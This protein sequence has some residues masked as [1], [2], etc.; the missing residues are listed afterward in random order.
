MGNGDVPA[1]MSS[2]LKL[3]GAAEALFGVTAF[4][5]QGESWWLFAALFLVPDL[6]FLA[7]LAGPRAG[8]ICYNAL[9]TT[10]GPSLLAALGLVAGSALA[11]SLA[12]IWCAHIG[13]D[14]ALGYGLKTFEGFD[15]THLGLIGQPARKRKL[16]SQ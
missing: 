2:F 6:T 3:E 1:R 11:I 7:Y 15:H 5:V 13:I 12:A 16:S 8:A 14:R 10:I 4:A 9:H